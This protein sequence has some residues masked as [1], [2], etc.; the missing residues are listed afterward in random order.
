MQ[1]SLLTN[2]YLPEKNIS[3]EEFLNFRS[4]WLIKNSDL[5]LIEDYLI[6][7]EIL[8]LHPKLTKYLIDEY[9]SSTNIKKACE[10]FYKN[11]KPINDDYLSKFNIFCLIDA[12]KIDEA[13]L[14]Y[15]LK[16]ELGTINDLYFE[17]KINYLMGYT[18][19]VDDTISEKVS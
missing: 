4:K 18:S 8:N 10:I 9:L 13:Q 5:N 3:E 14:L 12:G 2:A 17:K 16:K 7:N 6:K 11:S 1:V 15:D 19:K